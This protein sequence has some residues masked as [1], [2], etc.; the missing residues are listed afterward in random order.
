MCGRMFDQ[1]R[2]KVKHCMHLALY[3]LQQ[4][5]RLRRRIKEEHFINVFQPELNK[6]HAA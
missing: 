2:F 1:G 3:K 5:D 4:E 6:L